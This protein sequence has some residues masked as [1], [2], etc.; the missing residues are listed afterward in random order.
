MKTAD[1]GL[2]SVTWPCGCKVVPAEGCSYAVWAIEYCTTHS[3]D[4]RAELLAVLRECRNVLGECYRTRDEKRAL[5]KCVDALLA[6]T[7]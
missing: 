3:A 5:Y 1:I 4:A 2:V 6:A 7:P